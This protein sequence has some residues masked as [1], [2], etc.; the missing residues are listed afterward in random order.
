ML[1]KTLY[2]RSIIS[3]LLVLITQAACSADK[4]ST[5][6]PEMG[7]FTLSAVGAEAG[8]A[9][10]GG[11]GIF[12]GDVMQPVYGNDNGFLFTDF[13]GDWATGN[14]FLLSPGLGYRQVVNNQIWGAYF[15][16]DNEKVSLGKNFWSLSP[17]IEWM[18]PH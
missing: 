18:T 9:A 4:T 16:G 10:G 11:I 6:F 8:T 1:R 12:G 17:G 2:R 13:M 15:F 5:P 3:L 7:R 14:T